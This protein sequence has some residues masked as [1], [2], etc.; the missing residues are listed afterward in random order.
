MGRPTALTW[1]LAASLG[2]ALLV[3]AFLLGR[4]SAGQVTELA[5]PVAI[6]RERAPAPTAAHEPDV[7]PRVDAPAPRPALP[8]AAPLP[9]RA[10][11]PVQADPPRAADSAPP[12]TSGATASLRDYFARIDAIQVGPATGSDPRAFANELLAASMSG[13]TSRF[14]ALVK[15]LGEAH[16][17]I[18]A[19]TPP[20]EAAAH[21]RALLAQT[22]QAKA[23]MTKL[24][25]ALAKRDPS[26]L[27]TM[28]DEAQRMQSAAQALEQEDKALRSRL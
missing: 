4:G 16:A 23:M 21:H 20:P 17:R 2:V 5:G 8:A 15:E 1:I 27:S 13:D 18:A 7:A 12:P 14:D 19:L 28:A 24:G 6:I 11:D 22:A 26:A 25:A 3:I 10:V 9:A